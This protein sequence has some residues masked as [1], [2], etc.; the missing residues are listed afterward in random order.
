MRAFTPN[1]KMRLTQNKPIRNTLQEKS[2]PFH[3]E[4]K[5]P[6]AGTQVGFFFNKDKFFLKQNKKYIRLF[7]ATFLNELKKKD[8]RV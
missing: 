4:P 1:T 6:F 2:L 3:I 7:K 8:E 5:S